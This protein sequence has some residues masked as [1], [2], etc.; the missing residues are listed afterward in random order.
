MEDRMRS[1][2]NIIVLL[3]LVLF[4]QGCGTLKGV[5]QDT[6][7]SWKLMAKFDAWIQEHFW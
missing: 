3:A 6:K 5:K 2:V 1:K 4:M 7:D